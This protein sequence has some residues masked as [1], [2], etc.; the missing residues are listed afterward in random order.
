[1]DI[2][3][4]E[5]VKE[6]LRGWMFCSTKK[7]RNEI[8]PHDVNSAIG[9]FRREVDQMRNDIEHLCIVVQEAGELAKQGQFGY[10][11]LVNEQYLQ[12]DD[13][14]SPKAMKFSEFKPRLLAHMKMI[15]CNFF[16]I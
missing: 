7:A 13:N 5:E 6:I 15:K 14:S 2:E 1:M 4:S 10:I 8:I 11:D 9:D 16:N 3:I 12:Y